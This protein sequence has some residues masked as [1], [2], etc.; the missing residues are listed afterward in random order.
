[1]MMIS[2]LIRL[3]ILAAFAALGSSSNNC[4]HGPKIR[5]PFWLKDQQHHPEHSSGYP[6]FGLSCTQ[7]DDTVLELL[8]PPKASLLSQTKLLFSVKFV[9]KEIDYKL[10][11]LLVSTVDGCLPALLPNIDLFAS[12]FHFQ[13]AYGQYDEYTYFNCST[14]RSDYYLNHIHCLSTPSYQVYAVQSSIEAFSIPLFSC[15]KMFQIPS[16]PFAL[17][18]FI[19]T[20]LELV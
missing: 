11:S 14:T 16:V 7:T 12:P 3:I 1:M 13:D 2:Y 8:F 17:F 4:P 20:L 10:Q 5:F 18:H 15:T 19:P 6:G 9:I